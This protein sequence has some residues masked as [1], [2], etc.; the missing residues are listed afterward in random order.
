MIGQ[1]ND[2]LLT[3]TGTVSHTHTQKKAYTH[4][5]THIPNIN[6][7]SVCLCVCVCVYQFCVFATVCVCV[8]VE[9]FTFDLWPPLPIISDQSN[10]WLPTWPRFVRLHGETPCPQCRIITHCRAGHFRNFWICSIIKN[11]FIYIFYQV[12]N[13]FL[14]QFYL[15][16]P[17]PVKLTW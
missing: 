12:N 5:H 13:L 3:R 8:C 10:I 6:I 15:K 17:L 4:T 2:S 11:D 7:L 9:C 16:S 1:E 14:H